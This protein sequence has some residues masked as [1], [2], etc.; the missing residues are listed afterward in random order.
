MLP[1]PWNQTRHHRL[2]FAQNHTNSAQ[3]SRATSILIIICPTKANFC[4]KQASN[5]SDQMHITNRV[6]S[7]TDQA[8]LTTAPTGIRIKSKKRW[9][10]LHRTSGDLVYGQHYIL[11]LHFQLPA[12]Y[13]EAISIHQN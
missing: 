13:R 11:L 9:P 12:I 6:S 10:K 4:T 1:R 7:T 5:C 2:I 8:T 3:P